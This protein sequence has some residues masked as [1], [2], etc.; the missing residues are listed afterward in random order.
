[1]VYFP[2]KTVRRDKGDPAK[3]PGA[4]LGMMA[5]TH[6]ILIG[7]KH[8]IIKCRIATRLAEQENGMQNK[9]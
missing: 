2:M 1:M 8:G 6:E 5:R 7:T 3:Q 9:S 4:W